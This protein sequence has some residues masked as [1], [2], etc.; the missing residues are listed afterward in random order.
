MVRRLGRLGWR[1]LPGKVGSDENM[2]REPEPSVE[3]RGRV[4]LLLLGFGLRVRRAAGT[5]VDLVIVPTSL[6]DVM[7][8]V[9]LIK[10]AMMKMAV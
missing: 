4:P 2:H 10:V 9:L 8:A 3:N 1:D 5:L 6:F 7:L